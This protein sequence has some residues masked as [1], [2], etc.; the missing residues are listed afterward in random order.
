MVI[1]LLPLLGLL[2]N[3]TAGNFFHVAEQ[4]LYSKSDESK[5]VPTLPV[6]Y[7]WK[8]VAMLPPIP[9]VPP[10]QAKKAFSDLLSL[11]SLKK[12]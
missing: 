12:A 10:P 5:N 4:T 8:L 2:M 3:T 9:D 11:R 1:H 7:I 6:E